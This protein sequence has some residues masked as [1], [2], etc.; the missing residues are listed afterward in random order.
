MLTDVLA[1]DTMEDRYFP[2]EPLP[3]AALCEQAVLKDGRLY[4]IGGEDLPKHRT[5]RVFVGHIRGAR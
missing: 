3:L 2:C 1:Y 4:V 5:D